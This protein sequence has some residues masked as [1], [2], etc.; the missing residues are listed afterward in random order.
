MPPS[1]S[2]RAGHPGDGA[3]ARTWAV[4]AE[5]GPV[6]YAWCSED[7][8]LH[9]EVDDRVDDRPML[10]AALVGAL[11]AEGGRRPRRWFARGARREDHA[12]AAALGFAATRELWQ[13]RRPLPLDEAAAGR[14]KRHPIEWRPFVPGQD[15]AAWLEVNNRAFARHPD[16]GGQT[17]ERLAA[18]EAEPWF[19]PGGFLLHEHDG[20]VDG[21]CWTKVHVDADPPLGEIFVI[22]VDPDAHGQGLGRALVE[23]GLA[24]LHGA[25]L[26]V[27]MLYVDADNT[28][29]V[30]LYRDLGFVTVS[31]DV[32]FAAPD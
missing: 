20:R 21:F 4:A 24:W 15:E 3:P 31:R 16:Q 11:A 6:A 32:V 27:G 14:H 2:V 8:T 13:M 22:G 30:R 9:V 18:L 23:A 12:V 19:D 1:I 28:P 25:G 29:A 26:G 10:V 7:D 17:L 5:E